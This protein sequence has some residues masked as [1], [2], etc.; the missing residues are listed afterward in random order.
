[1]YLPL[2]PP[3]VG[4]EFLFQVLTL[5]IC[6]VI[7]CFVLFFSIDWSPA[8]GYDDISIS[9]YGAKFICGLALHLLVADNE[10][11]GL[12]MVKHTINH[13]YKFN[14]YALVSIVGFM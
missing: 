6:Q 1:M 2:L 3:T 12:Q 9:I 14:T 7:L 10:Q 5:C 8:E 13:S 4:E 11:Q